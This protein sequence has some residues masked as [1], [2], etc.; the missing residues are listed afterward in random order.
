M[1]G[2]RLTRR[3]LL[4]GA[5]A[6]AAAASVRPARAASEPGA[7]TPELV[8]AARAEGK[9]T[10]Y[11]SVDLPLSEKMAR[12]FESK[13]PGIAV[14]VER[15][16][17]ERN[18]QRIGQEQGSGIRAVDV[19]CSTDPAHF[20]DWTRNDRV[21]AFVPEDVAKHL[22]PEHVDPDGMHAVLCAWLEAIGYN[23]NL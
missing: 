14:R 13:Y 1:P 3:H 23:T 7:I 9:V 12:A 20:I 8:T 15:S 21:A 6:L 19:V 11:T 16:G 18:F 22:P 5:A 2:K 10:W 17:A 4:Q